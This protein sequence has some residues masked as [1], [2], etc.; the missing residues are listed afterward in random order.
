MK[1]RRKRGPRGV[2]GDVSDDLG[3]EGLNDGL[4]AVGAHD[5]VAGQQRGDGGVDLKGAMGELGVAGADPKRSSFA[6]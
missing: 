2:V 4:A 1:G 3:V 6:P 5:D